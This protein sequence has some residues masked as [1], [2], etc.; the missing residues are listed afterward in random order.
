MTDVN[1]VKSKIV[2]INSGPHMDPRFTRVKTQIPAKLIGNTRNDMD[3]LDQY[4]HGPLKFKDTGRVC[5]SCINYQPDKQL[6][7]ST[8]E[9]VRLDSKDR[10]SEVVRTKKELPNKGHHGR[11]RAR[12]YLVVHEE[13]S[14]DDE[15]NY[16]HP[17]GMNFPFWPGCP[18]Y[19][20]GSRLSK[21]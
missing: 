5:G 21:R 14:A 8:S 18:L 6:E 3:L 4:L 7:V 9:K 16:N 2:D 15:Q 17:D 19:S 10:P 11:C 12:G 13:T 1:K 20:D